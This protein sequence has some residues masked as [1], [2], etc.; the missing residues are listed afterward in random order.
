VDANPRYSEPPVRNRQFRL[1][2]VRGGRRVRAQRRVAGLR[3]AGDQRFLDD[4][5]LNIAAE[6]VDEDRG[7]QKTYHRRFRFPKDVEDDDISAAYNN[8]ILE[9]RLP[10]MTGAAVSGKEIP[11]ET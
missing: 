10:V 9:V 1:R 8:G 3:P 2:T 7:E 4:G 5:I 6:H 11:I